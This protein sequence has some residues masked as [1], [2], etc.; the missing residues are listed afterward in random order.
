LTA[1]I[2]SINDRYV[3]TVHDD[4]FSNHARMDTIWNECMAKVAAIYDIAVATGCVWQLRDDNCRDAQNRI[5]RNFDRAFA[6]KRKNKAA[7]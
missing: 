1:Q 5:V 2:R 6:R 4:G 7:A 3:A